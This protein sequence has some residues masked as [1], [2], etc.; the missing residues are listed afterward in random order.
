M[1]TLNKV[2]NQ[3]NRSFI[4][5]LLSTL[6]ILVLCYL[7]NVK[8]DLPSISSTNKLIPNYLTPYKVIVNDFYNLVKNNS[9]IFA[10]EIINF[11]HFNFETNF[12]GIVS[13]LGFFLQVFLVL[14]EDFSNWWK[15]NEMLI[16]IIMFL[17]S[18]VP[19]SSVYAG[20]IKLLQVRYS[21]N[22]I[23]NNFSIF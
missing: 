22:S 10:E 18:S 17:T 16:W 5:Y 15:V 12:L 13:S 19:L 21:F 14:G 6:N 23:N 4:R 1:I 8:V 20:Q 7:L 9:K 2:S 11:N 3:T